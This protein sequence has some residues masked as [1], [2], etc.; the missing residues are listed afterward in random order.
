M[1]KLIV[2]FAIVMLGI[3]A[4]AQPGIKAGVNFSTITGDDA[5]DVKTLVGFYAG[6]FYNVLI[7]EMF[8]F[9]PELVYSGQGAK[10]EDTDNARLKLNYLLLTA[11]FRYNTQS[12]FFIGTGPQFGLLLSAKV[13][14]DNTSVDFKDFFKS[15]DFAWA[16]ALGYQMASGFGFYGRY[17]L[18]LANISEDGDIKNSVIQLGFR[19]IIASTKK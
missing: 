8:S 10:F 15:T 13:K 17:N 6:F 19:Y 16:F 11:L 14:D 9:Q 1:K 4:N 18:G 2:L 12:G 5:Q 3:N 7:N